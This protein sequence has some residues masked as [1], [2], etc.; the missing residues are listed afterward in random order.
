MKEHWL[1]RKKNLSRKFRKLKLQSQEEASE[2]IMNKLAVDEIIEEKRVLSG[3]FITRD[4]MMTKGMKSRK[5][6]SSI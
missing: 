3:S 6:S 1:L 2:M 4:K 5:R